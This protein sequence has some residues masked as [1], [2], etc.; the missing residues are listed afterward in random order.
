MATKTTSPRAEIAG[1]LDKLPAKELHAVLRYLQHLQRCLAEEFDRKRAATL[2]PEI[3][4]R[5]VDLDPLSLEEEEALA[6]ARAEVERGE[7][8]KSIEEIEKELLHDR[9]D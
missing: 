2:P 8:G 9:T 7:P 3:A 5:G 1:M 4:A 6:E